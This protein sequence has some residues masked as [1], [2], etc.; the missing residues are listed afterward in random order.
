MPPPDFRNL[1]ETNGASSAAGSHNGGAAPDRPAPA[2]YQTTYYP[3]TRDRGQA[4]AIQL[5][6]GDD[7]PVNFSLTPS[8]SLTIRGS[9]VNLP[10]GSTASIMLQSRDFSLVLNG[11]EM[12]RDGSFEIRNVVPG[13]Y[14]ILATVDNAPVPMTARQ[15]LQVTAANV[16]GLKLAP[17]TGGSIRGRLRMEAGGVARPDPSRV[18]LLLQSTDGEDD[19]LG[20]FMSE[21]SFDT[22]ARVNADGS[23]EWKNVPAGRYSVQISDASAIPDWFLKSVAAGRDAADSG[24]SVSSG[25]TTLDLVASANG[26]VAEGVAANQKDEPVADAVIVAVPEARFRSRPDRYR[27]AVTDQSGRFTLRGLPPG[28]YTLFAWE[29]VD[30]EAYYNPE[31]LKS[32]EGQ[33]RALSLSE[34]ERKSVQLKAIPAVNDQQ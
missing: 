22:L 14:I 30:G 18:F 6:A 11:A 27:K 12:R 19:M 1:I 26:A 32:Y 10:P 16:E 8:P 33:G 5:H 17:Q 24:F 13:A 21:A 34:G 31:F 25:T 4:A 3:G 9:V 23:F 15:A 2:A 29:S 20:P 7:F 28:D